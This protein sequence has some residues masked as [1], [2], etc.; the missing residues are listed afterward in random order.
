MEMWLE[1]FSLAETN[2][3]DRLLFPFLLAQATPQLRPPIQ[4]P[5]VVTDLQLLQF[6]KLAVQELILINGLHREE[7]PQLQIIFVLE[8][9]LVILPILPPALSILLP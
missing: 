4:L 6:L 7:L 2:F 9:T 5:A 1:K 3:S 8:L